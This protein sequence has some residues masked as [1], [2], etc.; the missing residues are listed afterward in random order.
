[1]T[2]AW[3]GSPTWCPTASGYGLKMV[4]VADLVAYRRQHEKLVERVVQTGLPT[5]FGDFVA[6]RLS[7]A[8]R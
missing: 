5:E 1:M 6:V 8:G 7:L 3:P 2:A 4:T